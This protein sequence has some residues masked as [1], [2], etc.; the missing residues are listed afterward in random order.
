[1]D[2]AKYTNHLTLR[3]DPPV[4]CPSP[5]GLLG[6]SAAPPARRQVNLRHPP[7]F[8]EKFSVLN[9]KYSERNLVVFFRNYFI[10]KGD[11]TF[12]EV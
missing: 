2:Y 9:V 5:K 4:R 11:N 6:Q 8:N 7:V 12:L 3:H 1:M 10:K